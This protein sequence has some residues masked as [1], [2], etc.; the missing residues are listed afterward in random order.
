[1][2]RMMI[3]L[4]MVVSASALAQNAKPNLTGRWRLIVS[5]SENPHAP[6][7]MPSSIRTRKLSLLRRWAGQM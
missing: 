3:G 1:M 7:L 2:H 4:A 6:R 5:A